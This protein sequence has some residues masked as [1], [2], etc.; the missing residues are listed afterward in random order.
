M[1]MNSSLWNCCDS[2]SKWGGQW[3][4]KHH[5][6]DNI[7]KWIFWNLI[8][9]FKWIL[10]KR[11]ACPSEITNLNFLW[12]F[13]FMLCCTHPNP[14]KKVLSEILRDLCYVRRMFQWRTILHGNVHRWGQYMCALDVIEY[15]LSSGC[16]P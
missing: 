13:V 6:T 4:R 15:V 9:L 1:L 8:I 12:F 11:V 10:T 5:K 16:S 7:I 14:D 3:C 2:Y